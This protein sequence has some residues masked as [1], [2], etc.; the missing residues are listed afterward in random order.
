[1]V[2]PERTFMTRAA[3]LALSSGGAAREVDHVAAADIMTPADRYQELFVAVQSSGIFSDSK[4][5][6]DSVPRRSPEEIVRDYRAQSKVEGFELKEFVHNNFEHEAVPDDH[7]VSLPDQPLAAHISDLWSILKRRPIAHPGL[8]SLLPLPHDYIVPGG[9]FSELYY[10]D[11]YFTMLGLAAGGHSRLL[12]SMADNFAFI[13]DTYGHVPNGN[14]TYYLSRS[15]PP[16]FA[17]MVQLI[18]REGIHQGIR[19]LPQLIREY[20]Y[21]MDGADIIPPGHGA[22][23]LVRLPDGALLNRYWDAR[24]TP[25]EEAYLED[26]TTAK[27]TN[28]SSGEIYR[29]LRAGAAS[30]WDFSSRWLDTPDDLSTIKTTDILPIDLNSFLY[31]L[32]RQ[33]ERLSRASADHT[34]AAEFHQKA[35]KRRQAI[36]LYFWSESR[37]AFFDYDWRLMRQRR[38]INAATVV[39]LYVGLASRRQA[40]RIEEAISQKLLLP[41]GVAATE[42]VSAQQWDRNNGWAPLQW[43]AIHG[44]RRYGLYKLAK[45]I[46]HRWLATVAELYQQEAKLVEKYA[47]AND[48]KA[49]IGGGG[50]EYPL[51]DGFG[52]TNG[53]TSKLLVDDPSHHAHAS[54]AR[55]KR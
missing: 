48:P 44:L 36:D 25:R 47:I 3:D 9:R 28:R 8:S 12:H 46:S 14:R 18:E 16:V 50:G 6:V 15:Q 24:D 52:W 38:H 13:I 11:S 31:V 35:A 19:Y 40:H 21:W 55:R 34:V 17:L 42:R 37:G 29:E 10:W 54:R 2:L 22:K 41:G 20:N 51:Q 27:L 23:H 4:T 39:P 5:F 1:M 33:I 49:A 7:Y 30:G 26:V 53:V 45:E 32:E 43:M